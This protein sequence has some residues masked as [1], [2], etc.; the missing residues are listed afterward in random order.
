MN[1]KEFYIW[2]DGYLSAGKSKEENNDNVY[3]MDVFPIIEKM[4]EVKDE[5]EVDLSEL[6]SRYKNINPPVLPI[7][8]RKDDD[9]LGYPPKIVM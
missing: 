2:L 5:K 4:K 6:I 8:P 3:Y 9:E 1:Y 7:R